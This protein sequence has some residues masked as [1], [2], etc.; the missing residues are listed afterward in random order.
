M[1]T[2]LILLSRVSCRG[3]EVTGPLL[4]GLLALPDHIKACVGWEAIGWHTAE[5]WRFHWEVTELVTVTS[6]RLQESGWRDWLTWTQVVDAHGN[7]QGVDNPSLRM[8]EAD[9]GGYL[10]FALVTARKAG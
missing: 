4:R 5:W 7:N 2:E 10:S 9:Q 6:A 3:Q 1:T 8:L